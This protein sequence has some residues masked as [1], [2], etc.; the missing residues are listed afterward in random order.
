MI[1]YSLGK[2]IVND[3]PKDIYLLV[4]IACRD[5]E[6]KPVGNTAHARVSVSA[7]KLPDGQ[8][9]YVT[10][11]GWRAMQRSVLKIRKGQRVLAVGV[12]KEREWNGATY[13]DLDA[14]FVG[15]SGSRERA[16]R[17]YADGDVERKPRAPQNETEFIDVEDDEPGELPF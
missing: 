11:N 10:L 1:L 14:E 5:A 16:N 13:Y 6:D 3:E 12:F 9:M 7:G 15:T 2:S 17:E 8:T 4:G